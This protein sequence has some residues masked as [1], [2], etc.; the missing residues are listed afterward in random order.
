[1]V[2]R[3]VKS[4]CDSKNTAFG[5]GSTVKS[6]RDNI[7]T[8]MGKRGTVTRRREIERRSR[9]EEQ[10]KTRDGRLIKCFDDDELGKEQ[11]QKQHAHCFGDD[12][13]GGQCNNWRV[14]CFG[15]DEHSEY[16]STQSAHLSINKYPANSDVQ[17]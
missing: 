14:H 16:R 10:R 12:E 5:V 11:V 3:S 8:A 1:M 2:G 15:D 13:L 6:G 7:Y 4:G 17:R 9:D